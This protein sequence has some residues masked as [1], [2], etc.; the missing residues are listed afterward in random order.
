MNDPRGFLAERREAGR[1]LRQLVLN[2]LLAG[3]GMTVFVGGVLW[4]VWS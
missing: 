1:R 4:L 2:Y 3:L